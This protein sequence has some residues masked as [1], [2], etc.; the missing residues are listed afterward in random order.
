MPANKLAEGCEWLTLRSINK[1]P[2]ISKERIRNRLSAS[3]VRSWRIAMN[4]CLRSGCPWPIGV[5]VFVGLLGA[6]ATSIVT[7]VT[8]S[9]AR[10][11]AGQPVYIEQI[12]IRGNTRVRDF[13]IRREFDVAEG[14]PYNQALVD[15]AERRIKN[16]GLFKNVKITTE[17][18]SM[19]SHII[20]NLEVEEGAWQT[21]KRQGP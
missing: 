5:A 8:V 9:V 16:L 7:T 21:M 1:D 12:N 4:R 17:S 13:V 18:G 10:A 6:A 19:P 20:I 14:D 2:S 15:R 3:G 11:E